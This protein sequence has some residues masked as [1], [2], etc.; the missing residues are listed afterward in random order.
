MQAKVAVCRI[1]ELGVR[2]DEVCG[3]QQHTDDIVLEKE[4][5]LNAMACAANG[6]TAIAERVVVDG[7]VV[8]EI[9]RLLDEET[10]TAIVVNDIVDDPIAI[11]EGTNPDAEIVVRQAVADRVPAVALGIEL[12]AIAVVVVQVDPI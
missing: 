11:S 3:I 9:V 7:V 6:E 5:V 10:P 4:I 1:C 8:H 2:T 12:Q